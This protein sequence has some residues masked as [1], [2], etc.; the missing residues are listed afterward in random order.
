[1]AEAGPA[2]CSLDFRGAHSCLAQ[3]VFQERASVNQQRRSGLDDLRERGAAHD[4]PSR[5]P[6]ERHQAHE[7]YGGVSHRHALQ[8]DAAGRETARGD[9]DDPVE[10]VH[11][12]GTAFPAHANDDEKKD[13]DGYRRQRDAYEAFVAS[14]PD[15]R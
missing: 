3:I 4:E 6:L 9:G 7:A 5:Q 8:E 14:E 2:N 1:M 11:L 13:V 10:V 12:R 15:A